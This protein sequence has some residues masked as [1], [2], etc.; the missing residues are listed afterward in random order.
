MNP[1]KAFAMLNARGVQLGGTS[2]GGAEFTPADIARMLKGLER[3]PYLAAMLK[4]CSEIRCIAPLEQLLWREA[5][6]LALGLN[7]DGRRVRRPWPTSH[8]S[9]YLWR[10]TGTAVFEFL[11]PRSDL[12]G[13]CNNRGWIKHDGQGIACKACDGFGGNKLSLRMRSDLAGVPFSRW[14]E[15]SPR[16]EEVLTVVNSWYSMAMVHMLNAMNAMREGV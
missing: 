8:S 5:F 1:S 14:Q 9:A 11:M 12:C 6:R 16:Y 7:R 3:G 13:K 15:W 2:G 10:F 4:E